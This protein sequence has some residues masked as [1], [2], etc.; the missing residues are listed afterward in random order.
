MLNI[1]ERGRPRNLAS[2]HREALLLADNFLRV[3]QGAPVCKHSC[4]VNRFILRHRGNFLPLTGKILGNWPVEGLRFLW[5]SA[6]RHFGL[7]G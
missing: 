1:A 7:E 4:P 5:K 3:A 6:S 2:G